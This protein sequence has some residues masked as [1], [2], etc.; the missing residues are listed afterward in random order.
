M[1]QMDS[2]TLAVTLAQIAGDHNAEDVTVMDVRGRS[3]VTDFFIVC[4]G[5]SA[6]LRQT[7]CDMM[8]EYGRSIEDR[9]YGVTGYDAGNWI[10]VDFVNVVIH[11]FSPDFRDYY[12]L[13]LLWGD[14]PRVDWARKDSA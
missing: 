1:M 9:A 12:D 2:E 3:P 7:I 13:E 6:R 10:L 5:G 4:S 8:K 14:S 11:I